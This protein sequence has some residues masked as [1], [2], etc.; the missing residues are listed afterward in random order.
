GHTTRKSP[1]RDHVDVVDVGSEYWT[2]GG[3]GNVTANIT[4][5]GEECRLVSVIGDDYWGRCAIELINRYAHFVH[6]SSRP[7]TVKTRVLV[8][9]EYRYRLDT[10]RRAPITKTIL[11]HVV[12]WSKIL[13]SQAS[14]LVISDYDKGVITAEFA[15]LL[16]RQAI[17]LKIPVIV[18]PKKSDFS[19]YRG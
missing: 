8:D 17:Y 12:S 19:A 2:L 7:T 4:A 18:D 9:G 1:E 15:E 6:D 3:A 5:M 11:T 14:V 10:E 16:I 13:L